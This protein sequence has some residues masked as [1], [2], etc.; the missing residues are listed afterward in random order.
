MEVKLGFYLLQIALQVFAITIALQ[1]LRGTRDLEQRGF[2]AW[3]A[4]GFTF[5]LVRRILAI[6]WMFD[7]P[8]PEIK[9]ITLI[10]VPTCVSICY[11]IAMYKVAQYVRSQMEQKKELEKS[12]QK[13]RKANKNL[14]D[15]PY[16]HGSK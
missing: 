7:L 11:A 6:I 5:Q 16:K 10:V 8:F 2:W 9:N 13:L 4:A 12:F 1:Q 3:F 14:S 15:S